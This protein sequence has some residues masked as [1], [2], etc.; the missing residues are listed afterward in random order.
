MVNV[1][2]TSLCVTKTLIVATAQMNLPTAVSSHLC[3]L[4]SFGLI[5]NNNNNNNNN[6]LFISVVKKSLAVNINFVE[7][8]FGG[9]LSLVHSKTERDIF[10]VKNYALDVLIFYALHSNDYFIWT[11]HLSCQM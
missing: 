1:S 10:P 3:V 4:L 5:N 6:L 11:F 8:T 9:N 2:T 7:V